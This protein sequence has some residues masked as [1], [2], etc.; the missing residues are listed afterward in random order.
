M[1]RIPPYLRRLNLDH[2]ADLRAIKRAYARELKLIDQESD[3]AG[4]QTLREAYEA[5]QAWVARRDARPADPAVDEPSPEDATPANNVAPSRAPESLARAILAEWTT[6]LDHAPDGLDAAVAWLGSQESDPR[7]D[8]AD[9]RNAL[10]TVLV[11]HLTTD[12]APSHEALFGFA[13]RAFHWRDDTARLARLGNAGDFL[14]QAVADHAGFAAMDPAQQSQFRESLRALAQPD[15]PQAEA[16]AAALGHV[17]DITARFP[18]FSRI[19]ADLANLP[20]WRALQVETLF[21][22]FID[23]LNSSDARHDTIKALLQRYSHDASLIQFEMREH[24]ETLI[25]Q[26]LVEGWQPGN[27]VL[28]P[29]ADELFGWSKDS[30]HLQR[31]RGPGVAL[32]AAVNEWLAFNAMPV[33]ERSQY[34]EMLHAIRRTDL[35]TDWNLKLF[36]HRGRKM[37]GNYPSLFPMIA[38]PARLQ[39]WQEA[40]GDE[41]SVSPPTVTYGSNAAG[42]Q[43]KYGGY[44]SS[45]SQGY[46]TSPKQSRDSSGFPGWSIAVALMVVFRVLTSLGQSGEPSTPRYVPEQVQSASQHWQT[47]DTLPHAPPPQQVGTSG[48]GTPSREACAQVARLLELERLDTRDPRMINNRQLGTFISVCKVAD[49]WPNRSS[50]PPSQDIGTDTHFTTIRPD[51]DDKQ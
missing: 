4:F 17:E 11:E 28:L 40:L 25:V 1:A 26:R 51:P 45:G 49:Y 22:A 20:H 34:N 3:P 14:R 8:L 38:D 2:D 35:L 33:I 18:A 13:L 42:N 48:I 7:L 50:F 15:P 43:T 37:L 39:R 9:T 5:A 23:A 10:E 24:F 47:V 44:G 12:W 16:L 41:A 6:H 46:G 29:A 19:V 30:R 36:L 32:N 27:E 21:A 31:M